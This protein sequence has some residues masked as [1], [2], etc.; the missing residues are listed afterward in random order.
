LRS[1]GESKGNKRSYKCNEIAKSKNKELAHYNHK[2]MP[3]DCDEVDTLTDDGDDSAKE[4]PVKQLQTIF[5]CKDGFTLLTNA[6]DGKKYWKC[7][8]CGETYAHWNS[9]K[10]LSHVTGTQ[11]G[12]HVGA[13]KKINSIPENNIKSYRELLKRNAARHQSHSTANVSHEEVLEQYNS[14]SANA[15][16]E[17][18]KKKNSDSVSSISTFLD[19]RRDIGVTTAS[20]ASSSQKSIGGAGG[21]QLK[22]SSVGAGPIVQSEHQL[23]MAISNMIHSLGLPFTLGNE[24]KF[25]LVLN[26]A[27][28]VGMHY[29]PPG[30]NLIANKLLDLNYKQYTEQSKKQL[31]N[32]SEIYGLTFLEMVQ[33]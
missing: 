12:K 23:T 10:T 30:C 31:F 3:R 9:T 21:I 33:Q 18:W 17:A 1:S 19:K 11:C 32:E 25:H 8:W 29:K 4:R 27:Q 13:C 2:K 20:T 14:S 22:I 28:N 7:N 16:G 24:P 15:L 5:D 26:L 6:A